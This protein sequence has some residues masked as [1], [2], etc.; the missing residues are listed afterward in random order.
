MST[1]YTLSSSRNNEVRYVG[2]TNNMSARRRQ[3]L[4]YAKL[5]R[6]TP[7][8]KWINREIEEG[9]EIVMTAVLE[10]AE[11]H[12]AEMEIIAKYRDKGF[13]LLNLTDGGEGTI[14]WRGNTGNKRPDL[15][16]RNMSSKGKPGRAST[17]EINAKIS[18]AH[19]GKSKP[20]LSE[21]N[22]LLAGKPG[23]KHTDESRSKI[24]ASNKGR[25]IS[26]SQRKKISDSNTGRKRTPEGI[27]KMREGHRLYY[28]AKKQEVAT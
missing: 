27:A 11:L 7:V 14:G 8:H 2:Q 28:E 20:W 12:V 17:P 16:E 25:T 15:A 1:V 21:R 9:F 23:H 3:H 22:H 19:K 10:N 26:E 5:R 24:S 6:A 13:R 4:S 18:A